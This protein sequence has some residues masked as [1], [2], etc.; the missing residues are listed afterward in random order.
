[1]PTPPKTSLDAIVHAGR[2]IL[3]AQG[4]EALTLRAVAD[5]VGV[6][7]PSLYK[8]I[9]GRADLVRRISNDV[10]TELAADLDAASGSGDARADLRE[11]ARTARAFALGHPRGYAL[12]FAPLP[13]EWR[14]DP[15]VNVEISQIL[16]AAA[17]R[18]VGPELALDAARTVVAWFHGFVSLELAGGFRL[19]GDVDAAFDFGI[20]RIIRG[21]GS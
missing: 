5:A 18:I 9:G 19:G 11:I 6:R 3:E 2:E 14:I 15:A 1:V 4:F 12:L 20:D 10:A 8:R 21:L 16:V 17:Q 13:E 7:A